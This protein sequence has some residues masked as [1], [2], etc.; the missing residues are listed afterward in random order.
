MEQVLEAITKYII[1]WRKT[2]ILLSKLKT[3]IYLFFYLLLNFKVKQVQLE[4][5]LSLP[6]VDAQATTIA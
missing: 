5:C 2:R 3:R 4:S 6:C 1:F